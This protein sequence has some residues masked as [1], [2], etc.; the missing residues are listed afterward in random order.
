MPGWNDDSSR[1]IAET[2]RAF[3]AG[4]YTDEDY[5]EGFKGGDAVFARLQGTEATPKSYGRYSGDEVIEDGFQIPV[6]WNLVQ[7]GIQ[8]N[9]LPNTVGHLA[10]INGNPNVPDGIIVRAWPHGDTAGETQW[11]FSYGG[12][13]GG[14]QGP[15][16]PEGN[17]GPQGPAGGPQGPAGPQGAAG[18][19]GKEGS[20]GPQ[21]AIGPQGKEGPQGNQGFQGFQGFQGPQGNQGFQGYQGPQG[22]QGY[23]G[24]Q[25][26]QG[27]QGAT[28]AANVTGVQ[29]VE[30]ISSGGLIK[31]HLVNDLDDDDMSGY[32]VYGYIEDPSTDRGWKPIGDFFSETSTISPSQAPGGILDLNVKTTRSITT[33]DLYGAQG[34]QLVQDEDDPGP[35]HVYST[36][37]EPNNNKGWRAIGT[38]FDTGNSIDVQ[39]TSQGALLEVIP[40]RGDATD[41]TVII[42]GLQCDVRYLDSIVLDT[43]V[44]R[45][46]LDGDV[47]SPGAR[48]WYGTNASGTKG[49]HEF[50]SSNIVVGLQVRGTDLEIAERAVW[51]ADMTDIS[52]NVVT[53]WTGTNCPSS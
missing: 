1:R 47:A 50:Q 36:G 33:S 51:V 5:N 48:Y 19:Q 29:S 41:M 44:N 52:W 16:G 4:P 13:G 49:W 26:Y 28:G 37:E 32:S 42:E 31:V 34:I 9:N 2:V 25:G 20:Q 24:P 14:T 18:P 40:I 30:T 23:R 38:M 35:F 22:Y 46:K 10:E 43:A 17:E 3:E 39:S 15:Q 53:G 7:G 27:F 45:I 12:T 8:W 21:G 11:F 6:T